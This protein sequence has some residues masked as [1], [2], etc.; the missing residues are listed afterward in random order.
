MKLDKP[1]VYPAELY[2][3]PNAATATLLY[4][5]INSS[6]ASNSTVSLHIIPRGQAVSVSQSTAV[7]YAETVPPNSY[8]DR[9]L[10]I[11]ITEGDR[12]Y[13]DSTSTA[14]SVVATGI[15]RS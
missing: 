1:S 2:E 5:R 9:R 6:S 3:C 12:F 7:I 10:F 15:L 8:I 13:L 4:L 14:V 11:P